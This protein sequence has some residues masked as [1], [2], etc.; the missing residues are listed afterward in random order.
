MSGV[1]ALFAVERSLILD[2]IA[3]SQDIMDA[4]EK[5]EGMLGH[6]LQLT[7]SCENKDW[8]SINK[9]PPVERAKLNHSF[10]EAMIWANDIA[11]HLN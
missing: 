4:I 7:M 11:R 10:I 5:S 3:L 1:D 2:R 6:C 8:N 9:I